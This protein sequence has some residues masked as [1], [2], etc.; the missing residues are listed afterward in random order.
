[1][2]SLKKRVLAVVCVTA[3]LTGV[4]WQGGVN[5]VVSAAEESVIDLSREWEIIGADDEALTVVDTSISKRNGTI[6]NCN[7]QLPDDISEGNLAL[8][9]KL[10]VTSD[11]TALELLNTYKN[12]YI[13]LCN[14]KADSG[15]RNWEISTQGGLKNGENELVLR[16]EESSFHHG[17]DG[18]TP[19]DYHETINF[20]RFYTGNADNSFTTDMICKVEVTELRVV[21]T[22]AGLEFGQDDTYLQLGNELSENPTTIEASI[23]KDVI[24]PKATEWTLVNAQTIAC[25]GGRLTWNGVFDVTVPEEYVTTLDNIADNQLAVSFTI[26]SDQDLSITEGQLEITDKGS[27]DDV[28]E[29]RVKLD[30]KSLVQGD[31]EFVLPLKNFVW[32]DGADIDLSAVNY[33]NFYTQ[34]NVTGTFKISDV[35]LYVI[36]EEEEEEV[37]EW[38][39]GVAENGYSTDNTYS[40]QKT[41][42]EAEPGTGVAYQLNTV[43]SSML[44]F[45]QANTITLPEKY[46]TSTT[47]LTNSD[48]A[49]AFWLYVEDAMKFGNIDARFQL[50]AKGATDYTIRY[51][52]RDLNTLTAGWNY[53]VLPLKLFVSNQTTEV[54]ITGFDKFYFYAENQTNSFGLA[55]VKLIV[56][57][58]DTD[59][60]WKI[61]DGFIYDSS[62]NSGVTYSYV[63]ATA[64]MGTVQPNE[65]GPKSGT[66]YAETTLSSKT[67]LFARTLVN[68]IP[69]NYKLNSVEDRLTSNLAISLWMYSSIDTT[70]NNGQLELTSSSGR[71]DNHEIRYN[72]GKY[73]I[74][75]STGWNYI[76]MPLSQFDYTDNSEVD[77]TLDVANLNYLYFYDSTARSQTI[78]ITDI[79]MID[80][81]PETIVTSEYVSDDSNEMIFSNTSADDANQTALMITEDGYLAYV[82]G[83]K[84]YT[85]EQNVSTGDWVDV[86][87]VRDTEK[88]IFYVDGTKA[89]YCS[90][91]ARTDSKP[92]AKHSIGADSMGNQLFDGFICDIRL[93][94]DVRTADEIKNNLVDKNTVA[95]TANNLEMTDESLIGSWFL[96]GDIQYVLDTMPDNSLNQNHAVFCGSRANDWIDYDKTQYEFLYDENGEAD[97]WSMVFIPDIQNLVT[98]KYTKFWYDMADWIAANVKTENI[99]HVIGAGDS[100]W[101]NQAA[102]YKY[103]RNGF[104]KF[105]SLVSWSNMIGNHDYVWSSTSR[106]STNYNT[107]FGSD[108]ITSTYANYTYQASYNDEYDISGTENS[109]YTFNV[110]GEHWMILQLEY[111]PRQ[112]VLTWANEIIEEYPNYN[113]ILTTHSY[114]DGQGDYAKDSMNYTSEDANVGGGLGES[115]EEIWNDVITSHDNVK[116]V[117]CGH[118]TNGSG[119][120]VTKEVKNDAGSDVTALMLNAQDKDMTDESSSVET[121]YYSGQALGMLG[122]LRFSADGSQVAVQYYAP[123]YDKSYDSASNAIT[124]SHATESCEPFISEKQTGVNAGEAPDADALDVPDGYVFAGWFTTSGCEVAIA[125]DAQNV[126]AYAKYVS[127]EIFD[128]KAQVSL[129]VDGEADLYRDIR[130]VTSVD[131]LNYS[132]VGFK[133]TINGEE[134]TFNNPTVYKRLFGVSDTSYILDYVPNKAICDESEYFNTWTIFNV[135]YT[136]YDTPIYVQPYWKTLDGTEV[137]GE[138]VSKNVAKAII[139]DDTSNLSKVTTYGRTVL[140][141]EKTMDLF[142]T[143]S[144]FTFN[145][146]GTGATAV[147]SATSITDGDYGYLNVYVDGALVPT[148][149]ICVTSKENC[150]YVLAE[151]LE[152]GTHTIEVRKRNEAVF[153]D[154]ATITLVSVEVTGGKFVEPKTISDYTIEVIGDSI[155]SGYGNMVADGNASFTTDT[156]EGTMTYAVLA[157]K[158]LGADVSILSRSGIGFCRGTNVDSFYDYYAQTA[159]LPRNV[160]NASSWDFEKNETDVV[161]I[162][163]GTNDNNATLNGTQ[164]TDDY[165]T[166]EAVAF[167]QLV[168]EKNPDAIIIWAYGI[169]G[170]TRQA[171]LQ[172]AVEQVNSNGD[173]KVYYLPLDEIV[174]TTEGIGAAN[175]PTIQTHINRSKD[176]A[177]FIAD[178]TGW[179]IDETLQQDVLTATQAYWD[180]LDTVE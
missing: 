159:A 45:W 13:E 108:Y 163:L 27:K 77:G 146:T 83:D 137:L 145:F 144:G 59:N 56:M 64:Y 125:S 29:I 21:Y 153:G 152:Q 121:E 81:D 160:T 161:V 123:G 52:L 71:N 122:I 92:N 112:E 86:A 165:I 17:T 131:S 104:D 50:T 107:Y 85:L 46:Y 94:N 30:G 78:R 103:A 178:K 158:Q 95:L 128:V 28:N 58:E 48:L 100:T 110:N 10:D 18:K 138:T 167:L 32:N 135:P 4:I 74:K 65:E 61:S 133:I 37:T 143:N 53:V 38:T 177:Q 113:I 109:Y 179:T 126:E 116:M 119:A 148:K 87:V 134:R 69:K 142:W 166:S 16:F 15:E 34:S 1:M 57:E 55:D 124:L 98:G 156:Q 5:P 8:Y 91:N 12:T 39:L 6:T 170:N 41:T 54:S 11:D 79:K 164:V 42:E 43:S 155:T 31:N 97:Y 117:L 7:I 136:V 63:G 93:W 147:L 3:M 76:E 22:D 162:N 36:Q 101:S 9:V 89:G 84:Q 62:R 171:A 149:T 168:R 172:E 26:T 47:D 114:L 90:A 174:G 106:D 99:Q 24:E 151:G 130:F 67:L 40:A 140:N 25:T 115:T 70:L 157:A 180:A 68:P 2:K 139:D 35:K 111:Y 141:E 14:E 129:L 176:L 120:I 173:E 33:I 102:E 88:I 75:L 73:P 82:E 23:K 118:S 51:M 19:F 80:T 175:H 96:V 60:D 105:A 169:M 72:T 49:V 20:F 127:A 66:V 154:S 150:E 44:K 132:E